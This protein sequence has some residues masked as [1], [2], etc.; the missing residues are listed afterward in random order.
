MLIHLSQQQKSDL[1]SLKA[2]VDKIDI[3]KLRTLHAGLS[4]LSN[5]VDSNVVKKYVHDKLFSNVKA[6]TDQ[7][8]NQ[9]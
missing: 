3:N 4:K 1:A 7:E 9:V 8:I 5:V 6:S 2:E